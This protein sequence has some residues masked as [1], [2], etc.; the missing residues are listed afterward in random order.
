MLTP[1][2]AHE[3]A[4]HV[5]LLTKADM[6][7][8]FQQYIKPGSATRAKLSVH[9]HAQAGKS[10]ETETK[11]NGV[12]KEEGDAT[13]TPEPVPIKDVRS[14]RAGLQATRGARPAKDLSEYEDTDAK[15]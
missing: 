8:F 7:E 15:L 4:A 2:L 12:K 3:D 1:V 13:S 5:K 11:V 9:L 14:F 10:T 6:V